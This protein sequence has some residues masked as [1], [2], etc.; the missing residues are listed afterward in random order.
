MCAIIHG[1]AKST[2]RQCHGW[3]K[4]V[5]YARVLTIETWETQY[6]GVWIN[7]TIL[8]VGICHAWLQL[9]VSLHLL[10]SSSPFC[11]T[12]LNIPVA[13]N[14][15]FLLSPL[16]DPSIYWYSFSG[17]YYE[18]MQLLVYLYIWVVLLY[19]LKFLFVQSVL[20]TFHSWYVK[21]VIT[22][23]ISL[24]LTH[25]DTPVLMPSTMMHL[26]LISLEWL[27]HLYQ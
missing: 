23:V 2:K 25:F 12:N 26:P 5:F 11:F 18:V 4:Y 22:V 6:I 13:L 19:C 10:S 1:L 17:L 7:S 20:L 8:E 15:F 9:M 21:T 24:L 16:R 14:Y 27:L 3:N